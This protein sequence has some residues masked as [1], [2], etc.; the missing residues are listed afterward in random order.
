MALAVFFLLTGTLAAEIALL[1]V[2]QAGYAG[3]LLLFL[4][5]GVL[6]RLRWEGAKEPVVATHRVMSP[7]RS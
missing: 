2:P 7:A 1:G 5:A 3:S 4:S 6:I